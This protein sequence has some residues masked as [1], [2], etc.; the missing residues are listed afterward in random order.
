[1]AASI[2]AADNHDHHDSRAGSMESSREVAATK[3]AWPLVANGLPAQTSKI[4]RSPIHAAGAAAAT[5]KVPS[6]FDESQSAALSGP[7]A[8]IAGSSG[9]ERKT[10]TAIRPRFTMS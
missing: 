6:V 7:A 5:V 8:A 1:M 4:P 9:K 10:E 3:A 2:T